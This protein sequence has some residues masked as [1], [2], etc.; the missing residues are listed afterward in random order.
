VVVTG[1]AITESTRIHLHPL[2]MRPDGDEWCVGRIDGGRFI[3]VPPVAVEVLRLIDGERTVGQVAD[4]MRTVHGRDVDVAQFAGTLLRLGYVTAVDGE[5]VPDTTAVRPTAPWLTAAHCR[6]IQ[7]PATAWCVLAAVAAGAA[8]LAAR[9][10]L[11]PTYR[12]VFWSHHVSVVL[13]GNA[14]I[15]WTLL[16]LHELAHLAA[17]RGAGVPG[18]IR[19]GTRLQFLVMQTD[20]TGIWATNR[21]SRVTVHLA[22]VAFQLVVAALAV[23]GRWLAGPGTTAGAVLGAVALLALASLPFQCLL[24]MR[25]DLYFV[26]Q[27]LARC[28]NLYGDGSAYLWHLLRRAGGRPSSDPSTELPVRERR[29]V[30]SY[31]PFL[32]VGTVLC[33]VFALAVS[34]PAALTLLARTGERL[35][36]DGVL[37]GVVTVLLSAVVWAL[38]AWA[39]W[40]R[41]GPRVATWLARYRSRS[42]ARR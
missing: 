8:V 1:T 10:D 5:T 37:D 32:A 28:R 29:A 39:W 33:L 24:F 18:R 34:V 17:A 14:A 36:G 9:P 6:W 42:T 7:A 38:W 3:A 21:R 40:R 30:R 19:F 11:V 31:A 16:V 22:G 4:R 27:D 20:V 15:G 25:T 23:A 13:L 26:V 2:H 41:H 35:A 12:D